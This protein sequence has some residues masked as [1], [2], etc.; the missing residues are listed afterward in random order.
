MNNHMNNYMNHHMNHHMKTF[1]IAFTR[2]KRSGILSFVSKKN[3]QPFL[4]ALLLMS[5]SD[6]LLII[7]Q[8]LSFTN[9]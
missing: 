9:D 6:F 2:L 3:G 4:K 5:R 1:S 7:L 8:S